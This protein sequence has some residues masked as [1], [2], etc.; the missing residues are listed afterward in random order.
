MNKWL[1]VFLLVSTQA[2]A[3]FSENSRRYLSPKDMFTLL[4]QKFPVLKD[5]E[6][7]ATFYMP[8]DKIP[9]SC[10]ALG[11]RNGNST[12][13]VLPAIG[14]PATSTP[15]TA[16][17][18]WWGSCADLIIKRQFEV[19]NLKGND[20]AL[21]GKFY[22][23]EILGKYRDKSNPSQPFHQLS[24]EE[25]GRLSPK[26]KN[27]QIRFLIEELIGPNAVIAD[28]GFAKGLDDL[29]AVIQSAVPDDSSLTINEANQIFL[30]GVVLREEFITY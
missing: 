11:L 28:L 10:W 1:I 29:V 12:G 23:P 21:W 24:K 3:S 25:W 27:T 15:G 20:E 22:A 26:Q 13:L 2:F 4:N 5:K 17:V 7:L 16:F 14:T 18:R 6:Q 30:T 8:T 19:L 9:V